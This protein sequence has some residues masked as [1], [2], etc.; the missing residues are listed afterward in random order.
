MQCP[1]VN[2]VG[3]GSETTEKDSKSETAELR[4]QSP[5]TCR[6]EASG[7]TKSSP[8]RTEAEAEAAAS[9]CEQHFRTRTVL[10]STVRCGMLKLE[11]LSP[12]YSG[13]ANGTV[14]GE[15]VG[16]VEVE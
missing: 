7:E 15:N 6:A 16:M 4:C 14:V 12:E 13:T 5:R 9:Q 2:A 10:R 11:R 3:V 1:S 8:G